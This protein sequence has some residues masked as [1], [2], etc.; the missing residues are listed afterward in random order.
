MDAKIVVFRTARLSGMVAFSDPSGDQLPSEYSPWHRV[1]LEI[2]INIGMGSASRSAE[3]K[4]RII[5]E[6]E[7]QGYCLVCSRE[8]FAR[9]KPLGDIHPV[10]F[11]TTH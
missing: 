4:R 11:E 8:T 7:A 9:A 1:T 2:D 10:F 6:V 5:K 3:L